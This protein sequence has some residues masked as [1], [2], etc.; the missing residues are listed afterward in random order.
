MAK[1]AKTAATKSRETKLGKK[2][3]EEL[4]Q[5]ILRK[6]KTER[7][8]NAQIVNL[9]SENNNLSIEF[10]NYRHDSSST[11][12][13]IEK[14]KEEH[15]IE[16]EDLK[17]KLTSKQD[18]LKALNEVIDDLSVKLKDKDDEVT[19]LI[20]EKVELEEKV[21]SFK[22]LS[23]VLAALSIGLLILRLFC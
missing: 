2:T 12:H 1:D 7:N 8:L 18:A 22:G 17:K 21:R 14:I 13:E 11:F 6:D 23:I 5:I 19:N 16:V 10:A 3:A 20:K 4:I 15:S 9:K